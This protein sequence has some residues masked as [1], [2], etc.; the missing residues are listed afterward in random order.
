MFIGGNY[1]KVSE[2]IIEGVNTGS[3]ASKSKVALIARYI[4]GKVIGQGAKMRKVDK[5]RSSQE[6]SMINK[7]I[8]AFF[9]LDKKVTRVVTDI[10][11]DVEGKS[12]VVAVSDTKKSSDIEFYDL[13]SDNF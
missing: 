4:K 5:V 9:E 13:T 1:G 10:N 8:G 12:L 11:E 7:I 3:S 2:L 6:Q